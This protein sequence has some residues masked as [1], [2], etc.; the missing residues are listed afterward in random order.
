MPTAKEIWEDAK[1]TEAWKSPPEE[2][3]VYR[4]LDFDLYRQIDAV[5]FSSLK[6]ITVSPK[7]YRYQGTSEE[8][9][10][11]AFGTLAHHGK[12]EPELLK[13]KYIV[14]PEKKFITQVQRWAKK[15]G[16]RPGKNDG[17]EFANPRSSALYKEL[18]EKFMKDHPG[19]QQVSLAWWDDLKGLLKSLNGNPQSKKLFKDGEPELSLVWEDPGTKLLCKGRIDWC[20]HKEKAH[21]DLKTT[22]S[23]IT[24]FCPFSYDYH[25][26]AAF[27][28]SGFK[29]LTGET[30]KPWCVAVEKK[31][32]YSTISAPYSLES[33]RM[34][35]RECSKCLRLLK[36]CR[37]AKK[38]PGPKGPQSWK[39]P[40]WYQEFSI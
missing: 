28:Q 39:P 30:Y 33:L 27:Y 17:K 25:M 38:W 32:P 4:D 12:L 36:K 21:A 22:A 18:V 8:T 24:D 7:H 1:K 20:N 2:P 34:G 11:L 40:H 26:Q 35:Q 10:A 3:G 19:K 15:P 6:M 9:P 16:N 13:E 23:T 5:N 31:A 14:L 37:T 29:A